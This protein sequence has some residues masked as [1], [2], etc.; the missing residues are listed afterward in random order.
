AV[1]FRVSAEHKDSELQTHFAAD[2]LGRLF[3]IEDGGSLPSQYHHILCFW[4][5]LP[6]EELVYRPA[7]TL[8]DLTK[9][10]CSSG[11]LNSKFSTRN[12]FRQPSRY[13]SFLWEHRLLAPHLLL[14]IYL[15]LSINS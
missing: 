15:P 11:R 12:C 13:D 2:S 8:K 14:P 9:S 6:A 4:I 1:R 10:P 7:T 5:G 3:V